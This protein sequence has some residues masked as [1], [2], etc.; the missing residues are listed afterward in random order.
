MAPILSVRNLSTG[1]GKKQVLFDVSLDVMPGEILLIT[2][3]NGSGKSTLF[4]AIYGLLPP[5]NADAEIIFRPDP[6]GPA[7]NTQPPTL[8]LSKGLAY[9]PQKN[10]VFDDLTVEDNL[11][12]AGHTLPNDKEFAAR[13][14]ETLAFLPALQPLLRRK[15][16]KMSGGERQMVAF[17]MALLNCPKLLL[18]DEPTAGLSPMYMRTALNQLQDLQQKFKMAILLVEHRVRECLPISQRVLSLKLGAVVIELGGGD[19]FEK[20]SLELLPSKSTHV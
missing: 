20:N 14:E 17:G 15:P 16:E 7:L 5:W 19:L 18:L 3:G 1:Y 2:G 11:R 12:L 10:A 4:K 6:N 9:L 8:N 13:R